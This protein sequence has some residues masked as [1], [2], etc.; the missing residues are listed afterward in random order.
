[1][2]SYDRRA[3]YWERQVEREEDDLEQ[4]EFVKNQYRRLDRLLAAFIDLRENRLADLMESMMDHLSDRG[5]SSKQEA[6]VENLEKTYKD[7]LDNKAK[8]LE[9][10][11]KRE[12]F[13]KRFV[14]LH[15]TVKGKDEWLEKFL[16][17]IG[18]QISKSI[19]LSEKQK[20]VLQRAFHTYHITG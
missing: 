1:M 19:P 13:M 11:N 15:E 12:E 8:R 16:T 14:K 20:N 2:D 9:L 10:R 6:V 3:S 18:A 17:S 4:Q 7:L 5:L